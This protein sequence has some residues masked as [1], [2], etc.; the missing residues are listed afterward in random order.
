M[1]LSKDDLVAIRAI[2]RDELAASDQSGLPQDL[3]EPKYAAT[4]P[5]ST[6]ESGASSSLQ[7][8][9]EAGRRHIK[10]LIRAQRRRL[11]STAPETKRKASR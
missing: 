4:V 2:V 10:F 5:I 1:A 7:E 9:A 6:V 3:C 11:A 8:A